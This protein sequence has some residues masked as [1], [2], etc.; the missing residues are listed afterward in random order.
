MSLFSDTCNLCEQPH[1]S[2]RCADHFFKEVMSRV[3][4]NWLEEYGTIDPDE[5]RAIKQER[6]AD[7]NPSYEDLLALLESDRHE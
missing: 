7:K 6:L 1:S 2:C 5:I 4:A 3:H